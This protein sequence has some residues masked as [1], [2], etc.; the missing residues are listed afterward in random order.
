MKSECLVKGECLVIA[1]NLYAYSPAISMFVVDLDFFI[2]AISDAPLFSPYDSQNDVTCYQS[3]V[4]YK[5][6]V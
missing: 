6:T 5:G 4:P 2:C 1:M 3:C